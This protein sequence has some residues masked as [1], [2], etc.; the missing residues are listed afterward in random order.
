MQPKIIVIFNP[1]Y[2]KLGLECF[3]VLFKQ[4]LDDWNHES[5]YYVKQHCGRQKAIWMIIMGTE[6]SA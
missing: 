1:S 3:T 4:Q 2:G 5:Q 6:Q